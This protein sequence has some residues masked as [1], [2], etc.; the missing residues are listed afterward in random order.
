MTAS[1]RL[2][3]VQASRRPRVTR[4]AHLTMVRV[5]VMLVREL[6][7]GLAV[8]QVG[9]MTRESLMDRSLWSTIETYL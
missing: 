2:D 6:I 5:C 9:L 1:K 7:P 3:S 8:V 4:V